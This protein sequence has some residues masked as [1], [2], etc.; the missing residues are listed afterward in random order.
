M[1]WRVVERER[2][3]VYLRRFWKGN[4]GV[5]KSYNSLLEVDS[6]NLIVETSLFI[7]TEVNWILYSA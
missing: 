2:R 5:F 7:S 1:W 4:W 6:I 3:Y